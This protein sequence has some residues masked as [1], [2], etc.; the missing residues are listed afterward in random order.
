M[1]APEVFSNGTAR[2]P[3]RPHFRTRASSKLDVKGKGKGKASSWGSTPP[4]TQS[5]SQEDDEDDESDD[6]AYVTSNDFGTPMGR[7]SANDESKGKGKAN[8]PSN[9]AN[10]NG[11]YGFRDEAD[12]DDELYA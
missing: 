4:P 10:A 5:I 2:P 12:G 6:E 3:S 9:R 1:Q 11:S 8:H 7:A